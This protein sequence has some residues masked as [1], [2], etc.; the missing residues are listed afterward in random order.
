MTQYTNNVNISS[1]FLA[2]STNIF[3]SNHFVSTIEHRKYPFYGSAWH[4]EKNQF[5]FI[6]NALKGNLSHNS[7]AVLVSQFFANFLVNE[8][9]KN[10]NHFKDN[11]EEAN[12]LFYNYNAY[13]VYTGRDEESATFEEEYQF[14]LHFS[15]LGNGTHQLQTA[16]SVGLLFALL[17]LGKALVPA[18]THLV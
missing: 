8:A 15:G 14:P 11:L 9:R 7:N 4:P 17:A 12:H 2:V 16:W 18:L 10:V 3:K 6:V 13:R 1:N 5:E